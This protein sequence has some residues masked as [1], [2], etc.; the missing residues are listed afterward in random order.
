MSVLCLPIGKTNTRKIFV[1]SASVTVIHFLHTTNVDGTVYA[2]IISVQHF[3]RLQIRVDR[4]S[5]V[6]KIYTHVMLATHLPT[7]TSVYTGKMPTFKQFCVG[8]LL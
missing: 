4:D 5:A 8:G 6:A 7:Q 3:F 2:K 1:R